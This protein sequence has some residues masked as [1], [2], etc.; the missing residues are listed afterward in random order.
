M[1][2]EYIVAMSLI[3]SFFLGLVGKIVFDW[4]KNRNGGEGTISMWL[5]CEQ[6]FSTI[7]R[8]IKTMDGKVGRLDDCLTQVKIKITAL[9]TLLAEH[10]KRLKQAQIDRNKLDHQE[11]RL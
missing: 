9:E 1:E 8:D 6:E 11:P 5:L 2:P 10:E 3:G 4:L 7:K